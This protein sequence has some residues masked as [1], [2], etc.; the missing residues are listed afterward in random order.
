MLSLLGL[1]ALV[2]AAYAQNT[3]LP[4]VDLGYEIHRASNFN[5]GSPLYSGFHLQLPELC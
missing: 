1:V 3:S 2:G 5:V 4:I